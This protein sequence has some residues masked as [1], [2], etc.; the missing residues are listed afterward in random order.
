MKEAGSAVLKAY[1]PLRFK[2]QVVTIPKS[3]GVFRQGKK[4]TA[5]QERAALRRSLRFA[6]T[7]PTPSEQQAAAPAA[8]KSLAPGRIG[9]A[10]GSSMFAV[11]KRGGGALLFNGPQLGF[12]VPE[13]FVELE[14]HRP[15]LDIRGVTAPGI[16]VI[17]I[18]HNGNVAWGFTSGLSDEDD[19]YA[20]KLVPGQPEKYMFRGEVKT[21]SCRDEV[22]SYRTPPTDIIGGATPELGSETHRICRTVH[23][24]V[25]ARAEG[26]AYARRY[27][28]WGRELETLR[29]IVDLNAA[30]D[31]PRRRPRDAR[32]HL[33]RERRRCR[34]R[35]QHRLLA[36]R[37]LPAPP[38]RMGR[39]ASLPRHRRGRVA[40]PAL[41]AR[42]RPTSSTPSRAGWPTGTTCLRP[43][44]T[45][46]D[47]E[48][49]ERVTAQYHRAG[50]LFRLVRRVA[51]NPTFE[52]AQEA[53][54]EEGSTSQQR[55]LLT[56]KLR[57][58]GEGRAGRRG[59]RARRRSSRWDGSYVRTERR[60]QDGRRA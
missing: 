9:R 41:R 53:V 22:F 24:P 11:R 32:G 1:L 36:S 26:V 2:R 37:P 43:G 39:A 45:N 58:G 38:A 47:G 3:E 33:E 34:Q 7:L 21:M 44:W 10:G 60:R 50:F 16:P 4:R 13:L 25:Q 35:R 27:A 31:D 18:G 6:S 5:R 46:G 8:K 49:T 42:R 59:R 48:S 52:A 30:R 15:G 29:G 14:I 57:A 54:R 40:G 20:E 12:S 19:L 17:G 28:I 55:P 51:R 56:A 23:G